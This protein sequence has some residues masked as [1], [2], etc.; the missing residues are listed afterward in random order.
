MFSTLIRSATVESKT[1]DIEKEAQ[2][3]LSIVGSSVSTASL[4]GVPYLDTTDCNEFRVLFVLGT[5][6]KL[7]VQEIAV[8]LLCH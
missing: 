6:K 3:S 5:Y 7:V 4:Q 8:T 2:A 1:P